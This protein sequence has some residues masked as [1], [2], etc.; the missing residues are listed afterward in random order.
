MAA[1]RPKAEFDALMAA[2]YAQ[3]DP[4]HVAG[5]AHFGVNTEHALGISIYTLR[6]MVK[7]VR[8]HSLA[9]RLWETGIL[10]ARMLAVFCDDPAQV[11]PEQMDAWAADFDSW[12]ICDQACTSLFDQTPHAWVKAVEWCAREGEFVRR[13]AFAL[14]AGLAWHDKRAS[15]DQFLQFLPLIREYSSDG[16]NFVK[17]AVSWALRNI[18]KRRLALCPAAM[19][20][21]REMAASHNPAT[22]WVGKDALKELQSRCIQPE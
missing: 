11:T 4:E 20:L 3:A 12:D 8:D 14:I 9:L 16:R 22:R 19:E 6:G 2:L 21:A 1:T 13:A 7:G 10:E 17:K 18:G 15:D 5:M